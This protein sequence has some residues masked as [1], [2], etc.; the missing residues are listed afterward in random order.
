MSFC[1]CIIFNASN[2]VKSRQIVSNHVKSPHPRVILYREFLYI[3]CHLSIKGYIYRV[4]FFCHF[5]NDFKM[6]SLGVSYIII[7]ENN[8]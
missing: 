3:M 1:F 5:F 6:S 7:N 4:N 8:F 2:R